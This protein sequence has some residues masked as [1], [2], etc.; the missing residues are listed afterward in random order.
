MSEHSR[1]DGLDHWPT[2][3]LANTYRDVCDE[4]DA[5]RLVHD[6]LMISFLLAEREALAQE[7]DRRREE[8]GGYGKVS[9]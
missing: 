3:E 4:L 1:L 7:I 5:S 9:T 2:L 6:F 8:R